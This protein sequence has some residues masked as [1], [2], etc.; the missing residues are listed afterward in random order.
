MTDDDSI[1]GATDERARL[2]D[3]DG[4][5]HA[6][7]EDGCEPT[8][9]RVTDGG[10]TVDNGTDQWSTEWTSGERTASNGDHETHLTA[11]TD[12]P[13][14]PVDSSGGARVPPAPDQIHPK[15]DVRADVLAD[16]WAFFEERAQQKR[17]LAEEAEAER[18]SLTGVERVSDRLRRYVGSDGS[19][20]PL[21]PTPDESFVRERWFDFSY[22]DEYQQ[23]GYRWVTYPYAYVSILYQPEEHVYRYHV[24]EPRLSEFEQYVRDDLTTTLRNSLMYRDL[25][26]G[27]DRNATF[28]EMMHEV[29]RE[30][31]A[32]LP[33]GTV[34]KLTYYYTRDFLG[35]GRIDPLMRDPGI[36]DISC[37]GEEIPVYIYHRE[38]RDLRTNVRFDNS[39]LNSAVVRLAQRA[40]K[41]ISV[42]NPLVDASLPEGSRIQLTLG[43][44]VSTRGSN[45]TI[46]KFSEVPHT[47]VDLIKWN[48]FSVDQMAYFWLAIENNMSLVFAGGTGSG[49]TTSMNAVSLFIPPDSKVVSIEDTRELVLPH[50]N[51]VQSTTRESATARG[52]GDITTHNLLQAALRQRPEYILVGEIRTEQRVAL[53]FFQAIGTGHTAYSTFHADSV[54][55]ALA[56]LQNPPLSVPAQMLRNLDIVSVQRQ[57]SRGRERLRRNEAITE[58]VPNDDSAGLETKTVFERSPNAD[59]HRAVA[60]ST[61]LERIAYQQGW[62]EDELQTEYDNRCEVLSYLV[63]EDVTAFEDVTTIIEM[64]SRAPEE[65]LELVRSDDTDVTAVVTR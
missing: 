30:H 4:T 12:S 27:Q 13:P 31:A 57:V 65:V 36:E 23:I 8:T 52:E 33:E 56:R 53:T 41:H 55:A 2:D 26:G 18:A 61:V 29:L 45:F 48:T 59:E 44:D 58:L 3:A 50:E 21:S 47:P 19:V 64:Y 9:E 63:D 15:S 16:V 38:Y 14:Q 43:T 6:G 62:T 11:G 54:E 42:S 46:R 51:W 10:G 34:A 49:K 7:I 39:H 1:R 32:A 20:E 5:A 60:D 35:Y 17:E 40:G 24:T 28:T 25:S 22:L 37:D